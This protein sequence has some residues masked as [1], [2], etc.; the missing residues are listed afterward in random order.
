RFAMLL[1]LQAGI[2][3]SS[4]FIAID[5]YNRVFAST[6]GLDAVFV[7][8]GI[9]VLTN[10][11]TKP[12][13]EQVAA[14]HSVS[15]AAA[16]PTVPVAAIGLAAMFVPV[17]LP[18]AYR[19]A[20]P[21]AAIAAPNCPAGQTAVVV[22]PGRSALVLPLVKSGE[23]TIYPLSVGADHFGTRFDRFVAKKEE[24]R[25]PAGTKLIWGTR[26]DAG[27]AGNE[28]YFKWSGGKLAPGEMRGF[29]LERAPGAVIATAT[30]VAG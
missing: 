12:A 16:S 22:R 7:A 28:I 20:A 24:L 4:P 21:L 8:L 2:I 10:Y 6:T 26:L 11:F 14:M 29:C 23:G 17:L 1:W 15:S 3:A 25:Q 9:L 30:K 13:T 18:I 27:G 19:T 5:G